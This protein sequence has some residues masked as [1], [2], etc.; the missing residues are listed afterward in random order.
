MEKT[1]TKKHPILKSLRQHW[2]AYLILGI[3]TIIFLYPV[4]WAFVQ[5]FKTTAEIKQSPFS[6]PRV[7]QFVNFKNA[8]VGANMGAYFLNSVVVTAI[9]LAL[10]ILLIIPTSYTLTRFRFWGSKFLSMVVMAGLFINVNYIVYPVYLIINDVSKAVFGNGMVLTDNLFTVSIINAVVA[11]PFSIYLLQGFLKGLPRGYE[12]AAEIDGCG[13][14]TTLGKVIVP[15][16]KPSILTVILFQF[17]AYWNEYLVA[18]T[19]LISESKRT[20]P[21]GILA[22]MQQAR[23]AT[24]YGRMYAGLVI[25][26]L[27][28]LILYCFVQNN[29]TKG[30]SMGGLKG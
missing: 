11:I 27:P 16:C 8:W 21:V 1:T 22:I 2:L 13:H 18:Q 3:F 12:E 20:L 26:M 15:L 7:P 29:L 19:F 30:I 6:L 28:V 24:D 9:S 10:L 25:V 23:T 4:L 14:W 17:L 5:A